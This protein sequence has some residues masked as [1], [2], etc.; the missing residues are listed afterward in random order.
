M[1]YSLVRLAPGSYDV[2]R[3]GVVIAGVVRSGQTSDATWTVELLQ[4]LP[5]RI[6][7]FSASCSPPDSPA[8]TV[9][10][11]IPVRGVLH[12][13]RLAPIYRLSTLAG[14]SGRF[15]QALPGA[16]SDA[17]SRHRQPEPQVA[18]LRA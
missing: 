12:K 5:H 7:S 9:A 15:A 14:Q 10:T 11:K 13:P 3:D 16:R 17:L 6:A 1:A 8:E 18:L 4:D 2:L